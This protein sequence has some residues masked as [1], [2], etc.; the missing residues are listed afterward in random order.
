M[1]QVVKP[2]QSKPAEPAK[3][4][5]VTPRLVTHGDVAQ[6]TNDHDH[7][8]KPHHWGDGPESELS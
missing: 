8:H 4:V 5:Y 2:E 6:L 3:K 7:H 1:L